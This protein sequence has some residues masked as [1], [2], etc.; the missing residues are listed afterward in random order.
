MAQTS[1]HPRFV[2]AA[3]LATL[4]SACSSPS[5]SMSPTAPTFIAAEATASD[6]ETSRGTAACVPGAWQDNSYTGNCVPCDQPPVKGVHPF[7]DW[8]VIDF[9]L[10]CTPPPPPPPPVGKQGC[11]PGYW[12]GNVRAGGSSWTAANLQPGDL[13]GSLFAAGAFSSATLLEALEFGGGPGVPGATQNLLRAAVA[14]AL[15]AANPSV[16]YPLTLAQ[17]QSEVNLAIASGNRAAIL[18]LAS[19]LDANNNLGCPLDNNRN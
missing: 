11:T 17:I 9:D 4:A 18:D 10:A 14:A 1:A 15:N 3:L 8:A 19:Q 12:K 6:G 2:A 7:Y 13:V 16:G 5:P